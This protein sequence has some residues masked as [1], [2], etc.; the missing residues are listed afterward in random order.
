MQTFLPYSSF[1]KSAQALD[2]KRLGNQ[3]NECIVLLKSLIALRNGETERK[4]LGWAHHPAAKMW[5]GHEYQLAEYGKAICKE[6][7]ARSFSDTCLAQI[8]E[9]QKGFVDTGLPKWFGRSDFHMA[10]Q[11]NLIR[12]KPDHYRQLFNVKDDLPYLWK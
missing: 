7:M 4:K 9:L 1:D 5:K 10:H 11:S 8:V 12:K 6:W 3:R 2:N